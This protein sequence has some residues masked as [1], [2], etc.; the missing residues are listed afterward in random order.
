[1]AVLLGLP[2]S[3]RSQ[4]GKVSDISCIGYTRPTRKLPRGT[5]S[6][7]RSACSSQEGSFSILT[8]SQQTSARW[9]ND[10]SSTNRRYD[11]YLRSILGAR[12]GRRCAWHVFLRQASCRQLL[13]QLIHGERRAGVAVDHGAAVR[14]DRHQVRDRVDVIAGR[15]AGQLK[16]VVD[17][18]V[19]TPKSVTS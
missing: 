3:S 16:G 17:V 19:V 7:T 11:S 6:G 4:F 13:L 1:M 15:H 2:P 18:D 9:P 5:A 8:G 14:A 10:R 12:L